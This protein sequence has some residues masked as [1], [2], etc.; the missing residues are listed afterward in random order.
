MKRENALPCLS[1]SSCLAKVSFL[2]CHMSCK[3]TIL[4]LGLHWRLCGGGSLKPC[5]EGSEVILFMSATK[6][7][8][9]DMG[10]VD[11]DAFVLFLEFQGP[12][13]HIGAIWAFR[14]CVRNRVQGRLSVIKEK[15]LYS[16]IARHYI[17]RTFISVGL[18]M[19]RYGS[20]H[21][22]WRQKVPFHYKPT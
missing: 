4:S 3:P 11:Q 5:T 10:D 22:F 8:T 7:K 9:T 15:E 12:H 20:L 6:C 1:R 19:H 13:D 21:A 18:R 14:D 2:L 17:F 16:A